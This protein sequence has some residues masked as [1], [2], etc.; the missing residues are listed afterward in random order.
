MRKLDYSRL[1]HN[2]PERLVDYSVKNSFYM[3][4]GNGLTGAYMETGFGDLSV[5]KIA[6]MVGLGRLEKEDSQNS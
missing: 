2:K 6:S 5:F 3:R 1:K 4:K